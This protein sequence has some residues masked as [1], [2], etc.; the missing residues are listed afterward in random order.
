M[1]NVTKLANMVG[2]TNS[3]S[4]KGEQPKRATP[5]DIDVSKLEKKKIFLTWEAQSRPQHKDMG[6]R[7]TRSFTIIGIVLALILVILKEFFL[8]LV[9]VSLIFVGHVL[10]KVPPEKVKYSISNHGIMIGEDQYYWQQFFRFFFT[11]SEGLL[12]LAVD[13]LKGNP[14]RL[15]ITINSADKEKIKAI[16]S[17][18]LDFVEEEPKTVFNRSY[19][20]I[21]EKFNL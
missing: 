2:L 19:E 14:P 21:L 16:L 12:V 10:S 17:E 3:P 15:F 18:H 1:L 9:I 6:D 5:Q 7:I 20:S 8:I 11:E 4:E 13:S